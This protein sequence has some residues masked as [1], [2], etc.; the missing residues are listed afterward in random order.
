MK[1]I[2]A[3]KELSCKYCEKTF[4]DERI[5]KIHQTKSHKQQM[6]SGRKEF[7]GREDVV[8]KLEMVFAIDGTV[9]EACSY[10]EISEKVYY[11][12][13]KRHPEFS[14]RIKDLR[15]RPVL[16]ARQTV[17]VKLS[18]SYTNAMD[19]LKR[20]RADEF[21]DRS[22]REVSVKGAVVHGHFYPEDA[23]VE[24]DFEEKYRQNMRARIKMP[25]KEIKP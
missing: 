5:L 2:Q 15:E 4:A 11:D 25:V 18:E 3:T 14:E 9:K 12:Y 10:A 21:G 1:T 8:T 22:T 6:N 13:L 24:A 19:Y 23:Q 7:D 20:K 16:K 17:A